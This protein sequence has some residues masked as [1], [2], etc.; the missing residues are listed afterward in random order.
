MASTMLRKRQR[1]LANLTAAATA[2]R[3]TAAILTVASACSTTACNRMAFVKPD[4]SRGDYER[5]APEITVKPSRGDE[6]L[7]VFMAQART[8]LQAGEIDEAVRLARKAVKRDSESADARMLLAFALDRSGAPEEA[9]THHR[10]ATELAPTRGETLNNYGV[11]LCSQRRAAESL[12]W[13]DKALAAP[14][15]STPAAA[16]A[17]AGTCAYQ[18]GQAARAER[19]LRRA[20]AFDPGNSLALATLARLA[21]D[22]E[23]WMEARAFSQRRLAAAPADVESLLI[24]S[25]IEQKMGDS[26]AARRYGE[27]MQKEFPATGNFRTGEVEGR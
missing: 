24:A 21:F 14:G 25:Q 26:D 8:R 19:D 9:G 6:G 4:V 5:I 18:A 15:Y 2:R 13:F 22:Q 27:R 16:L 20:I 7:R 17:N 10:R 3:I 23:R 1:L 11:W 12:E